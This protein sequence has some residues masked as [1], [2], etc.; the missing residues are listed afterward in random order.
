MRA[1][2]PEQGLNRKGRVYMLILPEGF[3]DVV[4]IRNECL[5]LYMFAGNFKLY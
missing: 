4:C 2:G 3:A 1:S 5:S